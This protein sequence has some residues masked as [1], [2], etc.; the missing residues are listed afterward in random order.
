MTEKN[1]N[2]F[3]D[4][5]ASRPVMSRP[6]LFQTLE[7]VKK[8]VDYEYF[9][10]EINGRMYIEPLYTELCLI[11]AEVYVKPPNHIMRIRGEEMEAGVVQ[12]VYRAL[13]QEHIELVAENFKNQTGYIRKKTPYLQTAL[14]NVLFELD[15]HYTNLVRADQYNHWR[16]G[17]Q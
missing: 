15:A 4:N 11:I 14:Y 5:V 9:G 3:S 6:S 16:E 7:A 1:N 2:S 17:G 8:Q 12:E 13:H 10:R